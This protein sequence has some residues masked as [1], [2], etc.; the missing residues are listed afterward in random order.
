MKTLSE[1]AFIKSLDSLGKLQICALH[2]CILFIKAVLPLLHLSAAY[3]GV[4]L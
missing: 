2:A 1:L 4:G 3:N